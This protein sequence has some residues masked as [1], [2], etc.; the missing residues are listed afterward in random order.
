MNPGVPWNY[1]RQPE[2]EPEPEEKPPDESVNLWRMEQLLN[3][4]WDE[5]WA[6]LLACDHTVDLHRACELLEQGCDPAV[7]LHILT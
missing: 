7:A 2:P 5:A 1:A 3:A 6:A 4:G